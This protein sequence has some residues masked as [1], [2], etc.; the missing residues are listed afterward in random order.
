MKEKE[1]VIIILSGGMDSAT[2]LGKLIS[3]DK[4]VHAITFDYSQRHKKE[5][6]CAKELCTYYGIK[7]HEIVSFPTFGGSALTDDIEVPEGH[8][9]SENMK[10]TVV[11]M[12][13][14]IMLCLAASYAESN[15]I[16][17]IFYGAH[18]G[19]MAV[20]WDCR[21]EFLD[22]MKDMLYENDLHDMTIVAP[23]LDLDKGDIAC[24]GKSLDVPYRYTW[25][26]YKGREK[27]CGKCGSCQERKEAFEKA[28]LKDP[29]KY[30]EETK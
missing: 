27:A 6:E 16:N 9:S 15:N 13:N 12:R 18:A 11:P 25:T 21:V 17:K 3:E 8:Y 29:I 23:F 7:N 20:Y 14:A 28:K 10:I 22:R 5:I 2:L 24:L 19:D 26:C 30:E 1:K 4:E